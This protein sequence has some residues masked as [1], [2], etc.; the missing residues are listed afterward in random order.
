MASQ[1]CA[2][3]LCLLQELS[4]STK[5][6][7][8]SWSAL[9]RSSVHQPCLSSGCSAR[10]CPRHSPT[11]LCLAVSLVGPSFTV[12]WRTLVSSF[13]FH[14]TSWT[15]DTS[16]SV[17]TTHDTIINSTTLAFAGA[18]TEASFK[19]VSKV[20]SE[21]LLELFSKLEQE[22]STWGVSPW[23]CHLHSTLPW[24]T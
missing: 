2:S 11:S 23:G 15:R 3:S 17:Q 22:P 12:A 21:I 13:S 1:H 24:I 4:E 16:V 18:D 5:S 9:P 10:R 6:A 8:G 20:Y 14:L 19:V 7:Q